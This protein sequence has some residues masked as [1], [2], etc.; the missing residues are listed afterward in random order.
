MPATEQTWRDQKKLHFIFAISS[1]IML[2]STLWM[3]QRDNKRD[4]KHYQTVSNDIALRMIRW[5]EDEFTFADHL[6]AHERL[7]RELVD[8][9]GMPF[10]A[11]LINNFELELKDHALDG[12]MTM[13]STSLWRVKQGD[14]GLVER[15]RKA[16]EK[17]TAANK[18]HNSAQFAVDKAGDQL[19]A[20]TKQLDEAETA[21][22]SA[23]AEAV[24]AAQKAVEDLESRVKEAADEKG[25]VDKIL[26]V[27]EQNRLDAVAA[28]GP[29]RDELVAALQAF[30]RAAK[31]REATAAHDRKFMGADLDKVKADLGLAVRDGLSDEVLSECQLAIDEVKTE[32]DGLSEK[33]EKRTAHRKKLAGFLSELTAGET[34]AAKRLADHQ[35][36]EDNLETSFIEKRATW[37]VYGF[38]P[39]KKFLELPILDAFGSPLTIENHWSDG[40]T[41][42]RNFNYV[43]R[44]DRCVTCHQAI[45]KSMPGSAVKSAYS[46]ERTIVFTMSAPDSFD[47]ADIPK[48]AN[49]DA[50]ERQANRVRAVYGMG[51]ADEGL[52]DPDDV[53]VRFVRQQS[54]AAQARAF[55]ARVDKAVFPDEF[56]GAVFYHVESN[57]TVDVGLL[58]G[59]VI[60]Q[61]NGDTVRDVRQAAYQ[62]LAAAE[63]GE[64]LTLTVRRG[65]PHPYTSHPRLDLY[66]GSLSPHTLADFACTV[67]HEGQ[68]SATDFVWSSHTPNTPRQQEEWRKKYGW[69]DNHH[70]IFPMSSQRFLESVC[71]KCHHDVVELEPSDRFPEPPA[72]KL[73]RGYNLIRKY[74]C[75]GCHEINGFDGPERVGPDLRV[76][77]NYFAAAQALK[78]DPGFKDLT[79]QEQAWIETL[80]DQPE[81]ATIRQKLITRLKT[82]ADGARRLS[83]HAYTAL[84]PVL[85][86][87]DHPGEFSKPGPSLRFVGSKLDPA[88]AYSWIWNP[89]NFRP[90]TRMPR[91]LGLWNHLQ[92][93]AK[94]LALANKFEPMEAYAMAYY[95]RMKSQPFEYVEPPSGISESTADEKLARGKVVF[96]ERGCLACHSHKDFPGLAKF[97]AADE[98]QQGP[99]L[100]AVGDK[101]DSERNPNGRRWLYSWVKKPNRYHVRT[102]MPDLF[103]QPVTHRDIDGKVTMV[104]DPADD[105]T[106]FLMQSRGDWKFADAITQLTKGQEADLDNLAM[107]YLRDG[108]S[109]DQ[110]KTYLEDGIAVEMEATVKAAERELVVAEN[111]MLSRDMVLKYV[112]RKAI[113]KYGCFGCHDIPGFEDAKPI[114]TALADWGLKEPSKLAFEHIAQ[115]LAHGHGDHEHGDDHAAQDDQALPPFFE[116]QLLA[117]NRIGFLY[118]KLREPRGYDYHKALNKGFNERLRMPQFPFTV[119]EREAVMT[120]VLG[121]IAEPP[122]AKY[123]Y[124]PDERTKV[125]GDGRKVLQKFNCGGCHILQAEKWKIAYS[126]NQFGKQVGSPTY[127]FVPHDFS[128]DEL[129][130]SAELDINNR[131]TSTIVGMPAIHNDGY[132]RVYDLEFEE[133]YEED[134]YSVRD[135]MYAFDLWAPAT[136]NGHAYQVGESALMIRGNQIENRRPSEGGLLA[137]YLL[138]HV[139]KREQ[140]VNA[141]AKGSEAWGWLPPP[142]F[143]EG[144]KVQTAWLHDF[145]LDPHRIRPA[146]VLRMPD[147]H[148]TSEEAQK[149]ANYFAAMDNVTYPYQYS[150]RRQNGYLS[151]LENSYR[152]RLKSEGIDPGLEDISKR[153]SDAMRIVTSSTYCVKCHIVG[154]FEP[155][156]SDRAKAPDLAIIHKRMRPNFLRQWLAKPTSILRYTSM[157]MNVPYNADTP[158]LGSTVPQDLYHGTSVDQLEALVDLLMNYDVYAKERSRVVPLVEQGKVAEP[159]GEDAK[160][161][162]TTATSTPDE[163]N[164]DKEN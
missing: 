138:A 38:L 45:Q 30:I 14:D 132:P 83:D 24:E 19:A 61:I 109:T 77:P 164:Q 121:L 55:P 50:L 91:F 66:I 79:A 44:F 96:Q 108:Y 4:W 74:G 144:R 31:F 20:L 76:E 94:S 154:D 56:R 159:A 124:Q 92:D 71:L 90:T 60:E 75:Y 43:R 152:S 136:L 105:V 8:T 123:V 36:G 11:V 135:V 157:P 140:I 59:D 21:A 139:V 130:R 101:F 102:V 72:P 86:N 137:K 78:M 9:R 133:L 97:R 147:F 39:G 155:S 1:V 52:I 117:G 161:D 54:L 122:T 32:F 28:V 87:Q 41:Q 10:D 149:L 81:Q 95:L 163:T 42:F 115:Y 134:H 107:V 148:M 65:L 46:P 84:L 16:A 89:Q 82:D 125:I 49:W 51:L 26:K 119:E 5:A 85:A 146:V 88:F 63:S 2:F 100:S 69:F 29:I 131:L 3:F 73:M 143:N 127:P 120:F 67:C 112:G 118:Q 6:A 12:L 153:L 15:H 23:A 145:L 57:P 150:K 35:A 62:L 151:A 111:E 142:L 68:G 114:G 80:I 7:T 160:G 116:S 37:F 110:A 106:E 25:A 158:F 104:T 33:Y 64:T 40:L 103:L 99:D 98:I 156:G 27:A 141:N 162:A 17:A 129:D 113:N 18:K 22:S 13:P 126:P 128:K 93:D 70:W 47:E 48:N 53:T 34:E 58:A